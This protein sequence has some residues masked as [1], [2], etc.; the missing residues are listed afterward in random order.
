M[1]GPRTDRFRDGGFHLV[2][3]K[4]LSLKTTLEAAIEKAKV[5]TRK[6]KKEE[7]AIQYFDAMTNA[8]DTLRRVEKQ[9]EILYK[10]INLTNE[11][12]HYV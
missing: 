5:E 2:E 11:R 8:E 3:V 12:E 6:A 1:T 10:T 9:L 4:L 7:A